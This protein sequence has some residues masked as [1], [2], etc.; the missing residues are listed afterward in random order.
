MK[1]ITAL[2]TL[3]LTMTLVSCKS[4]KHAGEN[5]FFAEWNTPYGVPPFD[6][7]APEHFLPALERGMSLHDAEIDAITSDNDAPTFENV[8]LA[9]DRSGRMLAQTELIFGML[10]AAENTPE[11]QALQE[12][13]MPLLAAH[14]DKILLNE[15]LFERVKAVYDR[16]GALEFDAEQNRL[17]EKTYRDFVRAGALL[18]AEQ[19]ARLKAINGELSLAAVKFGQ[20]IL[21]ENGNYALVLESADLD[22][23]PSNVRDQAR[24]KAEATGKKGKKGKYVF[25][26]HKPSLIPFL[27]YSQK[28]ELREEIYKAYL[29]RCN[30]GDEYDNKQLINDFIRLRTEKAHL[31]GYPSYADYVVAD[32]MAGT[33]DAVYKLLNE[34]WTPALERAKGELAEMEELFR[35]DYPDGEFASWDWWYYAE[36]VRKQKYQL[37]EE[38]LRPYFSLEN[39]Q[40]GIF[41]LA[42]RLYGITFRPIVVPLYHPDAIAYEVLD[43]DESHLGVLY[44]DYFPRDGKSQGAWCGNYV[45]Q[46]YEDGKRVAP[47]VSIVCN[48][49]RPTSNAPAL[50][51]LDE[52]ETLFH[53]FGHALH[54]LF[55]DVKYRGLTEVEGDFVELPSQLM[56]NGAFDPEVL[57]QY[58]VHYRSNEVIP[59]YLV[60]KLRRSELFNQGFMTTELIAASL[61]DM[62]IHSITEY[63]PFDPME[64]ER[65][66]LTEKR[67]LI[68]QIEPRYRYPYFSHIFDG[69]YSA[70]YYFYTWAEVLDK[71]VFEAF[72]ESG[73]LFNKRIADDFRRKILARGGS[74]DGM[75]MYRDFRGKDPDKRAMLC[76]RGLWNEPEPADSLAG[77][78]EPAEGFRVKAVPEN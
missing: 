54:F 31:L 24:E 1:R 51:T 75:T 12:R 42:N 48:F 38:L 56:E 69:G 74:E 26:L 28:R 47:V 16:R 62:D 52:T 14:A 17:L 77:S 3:I 9:Y 7:I 55:H 18:D 76:S 30:N 34:I 23:I 73:D 72:R 13:V 22:G 8:I 20:N 78:P 4:D 67:G 63:E 45:E 19:K 61:S 40:S 43:A 68:P 50:L 44:F 64:F 60:A 15:K 29:N 53:E 49:T 27:T 71:D 33:T 36:K 6:R 35:K 66:A 10:C 32:E 59:E 57:K 41:F 58:A 11:M 5:P 46:T 37:E 25:T 70:G 21:A 65:K 39:V 2:L